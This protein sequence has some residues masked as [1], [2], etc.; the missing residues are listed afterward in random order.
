MGH[1]VGGSATAMVRQITEGFTTLN[2]VMLRRFDLQELDTMVF[3]LDKRLRELR[4]EAVAL[5]DTIAIQA[6]NRRISRL[7]GGLRVIRGTLQQR[8]RH[9]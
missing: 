5:E 8:R 7:E 1:F 2:A 3:E 6:K 4:G 9:G